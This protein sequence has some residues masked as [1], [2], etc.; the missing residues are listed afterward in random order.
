MRASKTTAN[1]PAFLAGRVGFAV[2]DV[3]GRADLLER[4]FDDLEQFADGEA[5]ERPVVVFVGDYIDR[6]PDSKDV[7]D[8]LVSGRPFGFERRFLKGNH[9]QLL[10]DFSNNPTRARAWLAHGGANTLASY[11]VRPPPVSGNAAALADTLDELQQRMPKAH[12]HFLDNL[13]RFVE[14]GDY[15]FVHAG[16]DPSKPLKDQ[17]D[18]DLFWIRERFLQ[19]D[20][21]LS[22]CVV[23]G[24]TPVR[25]PT[26]E[27]SRIAID[28]GA[29]ASGVLTAARLEGTSV[30]FMTART[31]GYSR[32]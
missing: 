13:E 31:A 8:L 11:G 9:E 29:Y 22:H 28:T 16:I 5:Q 12:A 7:I 26:R 3:H 27:G 18:T 6:G 17:S 32:A 14:A 23:H 10:I 25:A 1:P 20:K 24:H 19:H 15:L 4:M 30:S 21:P 2:G